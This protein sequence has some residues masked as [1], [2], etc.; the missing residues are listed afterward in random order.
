M[1]EALKSNTVTN[2]DATPV[3][4]ATAGE[5]Q[6]GYVMSASDYA[7]PTSSNASTSS[8]RLCPIPTTAKVKKV[9]FYTKGIDSNASQTATFDINIA[10]SD[11]TNDG[12]PSGLQA[13]I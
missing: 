2:L 7:S 13:L 10:F 12:T 11:A 5:G 6:P 4:I 3:I 8:D 9:W 1:A